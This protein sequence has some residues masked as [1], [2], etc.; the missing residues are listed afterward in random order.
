MIVIR[1]YFYDGKTSAQLPAICRVYDNGAVQVCAAKSGEDLIRLPRFGLKASARLAHTQRYLYFPQGQAFETEDN[2][3]VD[4][5]LARFQKRSWLHAVHLVETRKRYL[6]VCLA[7]MFA[8]AWVAGRHGVPGAARLIAHHLP[9][10]VVQKVAGQTLSMLDRSLFKPSRLAPE[11]QERL[12]A[13][14]Q[15]LVQAHADLNLSVGFR[16]GGRLGANAFALP[17]GTVIFTDEMV[18]L[19]RCDEELLAVLAHEAGHVAHR[20]G[21]QRIIQDSLLAFALRAITGDV[22]GTSDLFLGLPV[23][24]TEL[25]YSREFERE[26]DRYALQFLRSNAVSPRHFADLM[27]RLQQ[28]KQP[29]EW[30]LQGRWS[31]YLSTHP[32]TAERLLDF[33]QG[34]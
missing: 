4:E 6:L 2:R 5:A 7:A 20:H 16:Q 31:N 14:F 9:S 26:A 19:A 23:V 17:D 3:A 32:A 18:R 13:H 34:D 1:G 21:V 30:N 11:E 24:L 28:Q 27:R 15:A 33:E 22:S 25:A 12:K 29:H 8:I 10:S